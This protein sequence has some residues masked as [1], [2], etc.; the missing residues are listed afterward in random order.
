M[1][2]ST[3]QNFNNYENAKIRIIYY[4]FNEMFKK[5]YVMFLLFTRFNN[6]E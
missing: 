6:N 4:N 3:I 2:F 5:F 1:N